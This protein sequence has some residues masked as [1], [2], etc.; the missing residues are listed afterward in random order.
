MNH[1]A[2]VRSPVDPDGLME[3]S[4]VFT[5]R[6]LNH[7]SKLFQGVMRDISRGL[8]E[9]YGAD[10][11]AVVPGGGT[12][13]MEAVARQFAGGAHAL[14]VRNGWFSYRWSQIFEAGGFAERTTVVMAR[15]Q[16]N[17]TPAP[18]A[19]APIDEVVA[20]IREARPDAV[21]A[22]HVETSAGIIL[23]DDYIRALAQAA[24]EVGAIL[25][26]D[27]VA[28][29]C[30]WVDMRATGVDV[31]I[32]APQKGWSS[33]PAAGLVMMSERARARMEGTTSSSFAL[34]LKRWAAIMAAYEAG[35]HAYHAT[36]PTDSLRQFRDALEETRA[37]GWERAREAQWALG[38]AVR[39]LLA[40][41]GLRSVAAPGW[42][43]P[44]VVVCFTDDLEV[45]TGRR[46]A[47]EGMQIAAGVPL[48]VGEPEGFRTFRVGLFGL[49]KLRDV[50]ATVKRFQ[51]VADRVF[52]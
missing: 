10:A 22:P 19:P 50:D 29:G 35:G 25:V 47:A 6:S 51:A 27:G 39:A 21:F 28:S 41:K 15:A 52:G 48:Q 30:V 43:A 18:F 44:G 7:M 37:F 32:S 16:G 1:A 20:A 42:E 13:A 12:C 45:Q 17:A 40:G 14:V 31:L 34:D 5:D 11:V 9:A 49:D 23:P 2:P 4:V 33:T 24:H 26:L 8:R 46:F 3:F 38:R 36:L